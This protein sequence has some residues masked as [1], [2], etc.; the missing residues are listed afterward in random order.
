MSKEV[1]RYTLWMVSESGCELNPYQEPDAD[2]N[3]VHASDYDALLAER[4]ELLEVLE[5]AE[6]RCSSMGYVGVDGQYLKIVRAAIAKARGQKEA[7]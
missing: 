6:K 3:W 7:A 2:G 5:G 1:K 4:N